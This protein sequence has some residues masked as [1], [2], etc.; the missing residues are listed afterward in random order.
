MPDITMCCNTK[1]VERANCYRYTATPSERWQSFANFN[2]VDCTSKQQ[3]KQLK[4]GELAII[5]SKNTRMRG[6][7]QE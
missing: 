6:G 7:A 3:G 2:E 5:D 4:I 1:C